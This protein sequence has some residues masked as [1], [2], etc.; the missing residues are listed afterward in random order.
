MLRAVL[1]LLV[2]V[3]VANSFILGID[4]GSQFF[5][6]AVVAPGKPF[7]V[8]H[9][10][11]SKRKTPTAVSFQEKV[12]TFG[13]DAIA[14][15][16][17]G[18]GKT[19]MFFPLQLGR[20]LT[21]VAKD[22]M[23]FLPTRYY[24]YSLGVNASGS[25][26]FEMGEDSY[27]VEEATAH[28]LNFAKGLAQETVDGVAVSETILTVPSSAGA[29]QRRALLTA[30]KVAGLP[31]PQLIHETS[32]AA[33]QRSLD[34][35]LGGAGKPA[36][37][38]SEAVEP[39][40]SIV[41]FYN[42]GARHVE[43]C[44]VSYQ[45][46]SY[47]SK[48]TVAMNVLGCGV[49]DALGG[50]QVDIIIADKM[51][52]GF[53]AKY[54]KLSDIEKSARAL[55][56]LEKQAVA[57]KHVLSANKEAQ[58]RVES[59]YEEQ[60]FMQQV[61]REDMEGWTAELFSHFSQPIEAALAIANVSVDDVDT[62]EMVGGGWRIP[63]IQSLVS[64]YLKGQRSESSPALNLSQHVNGDEAM[65][66]GAAFYGANAS[67]SFRTKKIF[68]TDST[69][70]SYALVLTPLNTSQTHE[71]GWVRGVE[72]F[73]AYGKLRA[74]KTV[75]LN[76]TF[77]LK[78]TL[79]ENG[80][81]IAHWA[82]SGI[83][84]AVT[85]KYAALGTP[86]ISLKLELD[87]SGVVQVSS[88]TAIFD[89]PV[90]VDAKPAKENA[91]ASDASASEANATAGEES[92]GH[93][94]E[95][96]EA[97]KEESSAEGDTAEN[98][99][100]A[101]S[102]ATEEK[103]M[104]IKKRKVPL[105]V[106]ESFDGISPR[107]LLAEERAEAVARL[108]AMNAADA[109]VRQTDAAKNQLESYIYESRDKMNENEHVQQVSTE[110]ERSAVLEKLTAME[111]WLYEDEAREANAT[112]LVGKIQSLEE[113]VRP[114][115]KRAW[116]LEQRALLPELV[117]KIQ[118]GANLT[119]EYVLKNM[120]W[121]AEKETQGVQEIIENFT[122][123]W[124]NVTEAQSKLAPTE[125]P[126][127]EVIDVKRRL[128][129]IRS[130]AT[131]L[132]KIKKIDPMPYSSDYSKYGDYWKDPNM[133]EFYEQYYKN[134]SRNGTNYSDMFRNFN[135]SN[136]NS[137]SNGTGGGYDDYMKSFRNYMKTNQSSEEGSEDTGN[138]TSDKGA[139]HEEL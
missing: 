115:L 114:I 110:D 86:L 136:F 59:L 17:K 120:T 113:H 89:E 90:P 37:N 34:L 38:G 41:L 98:A 83:D 101:A 116:E 22:E 91:T 51:L 21:S 132:T 87:G 126:A 48:N 74:K 31:R 107:P 70:H 103:K 124:A 109:E 71:E 50:H 56:K 135:F 25:L 52:D 137:S 85:G 44:V 6:A 82:F 19:P 125:E 16:S 106:V 97:G 2:L 81:E 54:P 33:L 63:K 36:F 58:F 27:T 119:L 118:E 78:A 12:R 40:R 49:S 121:V 133:R 1:A 94:E 66:T 138:T 79:L 9:N 105:E 5:K 39:N 64:E 122:V 20:N 76:V 7:E 15:A 73:P 69:I 102:N 55:K 53:K 30:A 130:E 14:S 28:L 127:Y 139:D 84:A 23:S 24:P 62:V 117:D 60:D 131:R 100:A 46:A 29:Q 123:W 3:P 18:V 134:F 77:D 47:Q 72:L 32:A 42:M 88:A 35:D 10:Q 45:G 95:E 4:L 75:K 65:A 61:T 129:Q 11:H 26:S 68:F 92:E 57:T 67:V 128:E 93:K 13:D 112:V 111:D 99:S 80:N 104:K 108:A 8:V 43:A 96:A